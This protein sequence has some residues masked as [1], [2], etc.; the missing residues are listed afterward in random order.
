MRVNFLFISAVAIPAGYAQC[1]LFR[2]LSASNKVIRL[3]S[4]HCRKLDALQRRRIVILFV[5]IVLLRPRHH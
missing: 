3:V 2:Q 5:A 1:R 4:S